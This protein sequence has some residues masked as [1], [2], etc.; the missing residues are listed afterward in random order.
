MQ[1]RE[2]VRC[3]MQKVRLEAILVP[4]NSWRWFLDVRKRRVIVE[5]AEIESI[6]YRSRA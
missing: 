1:E 5:A 3:Q 6:E 2:P 4:A